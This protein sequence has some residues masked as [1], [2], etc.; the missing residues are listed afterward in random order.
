M[1]LYCPTSPGTSQSQ[2]QQPILQ[3]VLRR[4]FVNFK[5]NFKSYFYGIPLG[6]SLVFSGSTLFIEECPGFPGL[7]FT[8]WPPVT[9]VASSLITAHAA[10]PQR[11]FLPLAVPRLL[12]LFHTHL[13]PISLDTLENSCPSFKTTWLR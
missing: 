10:A 6:S 8:M 11:S 1:T 7:L 12:F 2:A 3:T 13:L 4:N 5:Y 9:R